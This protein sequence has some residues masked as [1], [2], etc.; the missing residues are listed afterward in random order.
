M[1]RYF[2]FSLAVAAT[3]VAQI[4]TNLT[5]HQLTTQYLP[6]VSINTAYILNDTRAS[7]QLAN[8]TNDPLTIFLSLNTPFEQFAATPPPSVAAG[9]IETA[10]ATNADLNSNLFQYLQLDG[11]HLSAT[12]NGTSFMRTRFKNYLYE[13]VIGG[14]N[15]EVFRNESAFFVGTGIG[16]KSNV[17]IPACI[18]MRTVTLRR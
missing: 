13:N 15:I 8:A 2:A 4:P 5:F 1:Y 7:E 14:Q 10:S 3:A 16:F 12:F 9:Q 11:I 17:V 6:F 18:S